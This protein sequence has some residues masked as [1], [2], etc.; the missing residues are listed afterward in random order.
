M[1]SFFYDLI[2]PFLSDNSPRLGLK[3][4]VIVKKI[5]KGALML[6]IVKQLWKKYTDWCDA[7]GLGPESQRCCAPRLSEPDANSDDNSNE[8]RNERNREYKN[9]A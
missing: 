4:K 1:S 5:P 7:M 9:R 3:L 8:A 6:A 2:F